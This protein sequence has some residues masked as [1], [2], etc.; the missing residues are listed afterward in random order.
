MACPPSRP[1]SDP[2]L[3]ALKAF[4]IPSAVVTNSRSFGYI[5][6]IR[7]AMSN[8]SSCIRA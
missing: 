3:P 6:I 5:A 8:S 7:R 4:S 1:S 2:I